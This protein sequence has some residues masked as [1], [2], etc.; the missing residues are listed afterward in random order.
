M[1][2]K[3][4]IIKNCAVRQ[5][6]ESIYFISVSV[7]ITLLFVVTACYIYLLIAQHSV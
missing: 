3:Y 5:L 7:S 1:V 2:N 4:P 6:P